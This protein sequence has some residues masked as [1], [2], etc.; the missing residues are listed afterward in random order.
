MKICVVREGSFSFLPYVS[1]VVCARHTIYESF[2]LVGWNSIHRAAAESRS[3][4]S[5]TES[6][7]FAANRYESLELRTAD[8]IVIAATVM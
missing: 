2:H 5:C 7:L 6:S 4:Q 1:L 8:F 3:R